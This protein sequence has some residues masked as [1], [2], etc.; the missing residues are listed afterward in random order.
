V[1]F[2]A[3]AGSAGAVTLSLPVTSGGGWLAAAPG[4]FTSVSCASASRC[5]AVGGSGDVVRW[6]GARWSAPVPLDRDGGGLT[7]VSCPRSGPCTAVDF[8]GRQLQ[9]AA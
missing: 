6:N 7:G 9:F 3:L 8:D 1:S 5:V 4:G 2:C